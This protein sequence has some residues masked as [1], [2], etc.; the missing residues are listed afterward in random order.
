M[1]ENNLGRDIAH[2]GILQGDQ[3]FRRLDLVD[4]LDLVDKYVLERIN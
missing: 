2:D 3:R 1:K 4:G